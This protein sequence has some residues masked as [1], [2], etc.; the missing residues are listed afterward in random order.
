MKIK[1]KKPNRR[2]MVDGSAKGSQ[3]LRIAP[4]LRQVCLR[5]G[6]DSM[7]SFDRQ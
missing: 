1:K 2:G 5:K 6:R 3:S 4:F 7:D